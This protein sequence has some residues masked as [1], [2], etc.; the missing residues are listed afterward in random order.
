VFSVDAK[1]ATRIAP[2]IRRVLIVDAGSAAAKLLA[3]LMKGMGTRETVLVSD[4]IAG[5]EAA[6]DFEPT[7]IFT[8]R[9]GEALD[10]ESLTR[11]IRR[12]SLACRKAPII[13][14]TGE[15]TAAAILGARDVGVHEFL[16]KPF[17]GGDLLRRVEAVATRPRDWI[18][19]V[20]YVGPDRRRFNSG[21]YAGPRKRQVDKPKSVSEA[22]AAAKDQAMRILASAHAQFDSDPMQ[23]LRAMRD[24]ASTLK[25]LA[26]KLSDTSLVIAAS[27]L[28]TALADA[29]ATKAD[30][31]K[32]VSAVLA[33]VPPE[34][35]ARAG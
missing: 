7:L 30:L 32:P 14:V 28:E 25:T 11:R 16:R 12:S 17:T 8:E 9:R 2:C 15:A 18:E 4:E 35:L 22:N 19:A 13:M 33:L 31:A 3:E 29:R 21:E 5:L 26:V 23:A 10:G 27:A 20:G 6:R 1:V 24:Q 34:T